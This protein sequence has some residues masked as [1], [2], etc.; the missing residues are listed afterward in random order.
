MVC[1]ETDQSGGYVPELKLLACAEAAKG[2]EENHR[3]I[4]L[5]ANRA[6]PKEV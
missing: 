6:K 4:D 5:T 3:K 1:A 2:Y